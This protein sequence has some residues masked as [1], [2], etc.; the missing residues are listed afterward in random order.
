MISFGFSNTKQANGSPVGGQV[1]GAQAVGGEAEGLG[2]S[3]PGE[4]KARGG[5][6]TAP[7]KTYKQLLRQKT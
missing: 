3:Q 4:F 6:L 1:A 5:T 7:S 2:L